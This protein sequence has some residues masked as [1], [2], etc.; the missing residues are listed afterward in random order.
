M[1]ASLLAVAKSIYYIRIKLKNHFKNTHC[2]FFEQFSCRKRMLF[3]QSLGVECKVCLHES[4]KREGSK[5]PKPIFSNSAKG[6]FKA[7]L[8]TNYLVLNFCSPDFIEFTGNTYYLVR[9]SVTA[10][11]LSDSNF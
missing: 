10:R 2:E 8:Q 7:D 11:R 5:V 1:G 9:K 3:M 4:H 6:Y